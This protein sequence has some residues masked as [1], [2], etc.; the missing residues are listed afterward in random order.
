MPQSL[1]LFKKIFT[2]EEWIVLKMH[3]AFCLLLAAA[4]LLPMV[5]SGCVFLPAAPTEP[6]DPQPTEPTEPEKEVYHGMTASQLDAIPGVNYDAFRNA[7]DSGWNFGWDAVVSSEAVAGKV[8][9]TGA[10][11]DRAVWHLGTDAQ[12]CATENTGWGVA[13][14]AT[15]K[16]SVAYMYNKVRIPASITQLRV[17]AVGNKD[18]VSSGEGAMR[19]VAVYKDENGQYVTQTLKALSNSFT[20][21]AT[22]YY[23]EDGTVRFKNANWSMPGTDS[24]MI[25]YDVSTLPRDKDVILFIESVGMGNVLGDE[26]TEAAEG[27]P[28]GQVMSDLVVV[29]RVMVVA[30]S[31]PVEDGTEID[32]PT[33]DSE[34]E[35]LF[36]I[37]GNDG[38]FL[39]FLP[40]TTRKYE[41]APLLLL[42]CGGGWREQSRASILGMMSPMVAD[43]RADGFAVVAADY[44]L[45]SDS[46]S[47]T[48]EEQV[49]DLFDALAYV[50]H[51]ADVLG[52]DPQRI[53]TSGHSAGA[54]LALM[55]AHAPR[56]QFP[57]EGFAADYQ[58]FASAPFAAV[59]T[60]L[61]AD[62][63]WSYIA[64]RNGVFDPE[65]G[66]K[67]SPVTYVSADNAP[68][69]I[70]HGNMDEV[71]PFALNAQ[72]IMNKA[73]EVGAP[74]E[75]L[76]SEYGNHSFVSA[77]RGHKASP[78][79]TEACHIAADWI[80]SRLTK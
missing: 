19:T 67:L 30:T 1:P 65:L 4:M 31:V 46:N 11:A 61:T 41:K 79:L 22:K 73:N 57:T 14:R 12:G 62:I 44:R 76:V 32:V 20:S 72:G 2:K 36:K 33:N 70:I 6:T 52:I 77:V 10:A 25:Y 75:L 47:L 78:D 40:P 26:Y 63:Y 58:I 18:Y 39:N 43:L 28:A 15:G 38:L 45:I 51:Y 21:Q 13:L 3:R 42:I 9:F 69:L 7:M 66:K 56:E 68:T 34:Q 27:T 59:T 49:A 80:V 35:L 55:V 71:V 74:Y 17:W 8:D 53:A 5:L 48:A 23:A 50:V 60:V 16:G 37:A 24:G 64:N 29:K 54:H